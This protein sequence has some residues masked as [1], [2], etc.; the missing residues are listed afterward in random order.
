VTDPA[1]RPSNFPWPPLIYLAA[2]A[3]SIALWLLFPLPWLG[4]P[5]S[6]ILFAVGCVMV[7]A[8]IGI[9]FSAMRTLARAK[10]TIRPD[11]ASTH[12]VTTGAFSFSRNPIYLANTLIMLAAALVAGIAWFIPLALIAAFL[13]QKLAIEGEEKHLALRFGK[14]YQ[15][16]RKRVRRWI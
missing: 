3:V 7:V 14:K 16:Y 5:L 4:S 15:D 12:L 1:T 8:V 11:K 13:T 2:I 9:D 10:T 6:D